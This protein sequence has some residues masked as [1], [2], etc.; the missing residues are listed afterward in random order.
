MDLDTPDTYWKFEGNFIEEIPENAYGF[1]YKITNLDNKKI[2]IGR[3]NFFHTRKKKLGKR[4]V[5]KLKDKR[6]SKVYYE[7]KES[8]WKDYCGSCEELIVDISAGNKIKKEILI[9]CSTK[10]LLTYYETKYQFDLNVL[11]TDTYN[12][13]ILGRYYRKLFT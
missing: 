6:A 5:A 7:T 3:K 8:D 1:V 2:Y 9:F 10:Q 11:E 12:N 4:A 13:N